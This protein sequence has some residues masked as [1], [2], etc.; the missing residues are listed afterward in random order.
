MEQRHSGSMSQL[1]RTSQ[2]EV[3]TCRGRFLPGPRLAASPHQGVGAITP[4][5][6]A[7]GHT[8]GAGEGKTAW[9]QRKHPHPY[10][11]THSWSRQLQTT[12]QSCSQSST[13][14]NSQLWK[15]SER[16]QSRGRKM[17]LASCVRQDGDVPP[18]LHRTVRRRQNFTLLCVQFTETRGS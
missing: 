1:L 11:H 5:G 13:Q 10:A 7:E 3:A 4:K 12:A 17:P 15:R 18:C 2:N 8:G 9:T 16:P 14:G 6:R